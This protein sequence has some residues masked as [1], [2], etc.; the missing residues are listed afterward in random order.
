MSDSLFYF[1]AFFSSSRDA[2]G[3][4]AAA[5]CPGFLTVSVSSICPRILPPKICRKYDIVPRSSMP[6]T[7]ENTIFIGVLIFS[8]VMPSAGFAPFPFPLF[9]RLFAAL[10]SDVSPVSR[11]FVFIRLYSI[12]S[13]ILCYCLLINL[14]MPTQKGDARL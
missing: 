3:G 5:A 8:P 13:G 4:S 7:T 2:F 14:N 10:F 1:G 11:P 6:K 9:F 12:F